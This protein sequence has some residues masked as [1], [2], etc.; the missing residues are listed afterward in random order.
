LK[1]YTTGDSLNPLYLQ[2]YR[3]GTID[4][5]GPNLPVAPTTIPL[6]TWTDS[7]PPTAL[8]LA[9]LA[10]P[11]NIGSLVINMPVTALTASDWWGNG[12]VRVGLHPTVYSCVWAAAGSNDGNMYQPVIPPTNRT[13][14][15]GSRGYSSSTTPATSTGARHNGALTLQIIAANTPQAS[16]EMNVAGR[17]EYGWR[18]K[19]ADYGTYVLMEYS[20]YWHHPNGKCFNSTGWTDQP[21][22][23]TANNAA[24]QRPAGTT[25]PKL[26]DLSA[27]T[28]TT[29]GSITSSTTSVTGNVSTTTIHYS[30]GGIATIVRTAN[31]DGTVTIVTTDAVGAVTTQTIAN[32]SGTLATGGDERRDAMAS[33]GRISWRELLSP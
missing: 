14:G 28:G 19:S 15:P 3:R 7:A 29:G 22:P 18:V 24:G 17:P 27:A 25:D 1:N 9:Q 32:A 30:S 10:A 16:L 2:T 5:S 20:I 11:R 13:N 8:Q 6:R 31:A 26:G 33:T 4:W 12:D 21:G 23:D